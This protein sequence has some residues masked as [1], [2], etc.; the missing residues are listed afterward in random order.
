MTA[1]V[2][3]MKAYHD[4]MSAH[5]DPVHAPAVGAG[6]GDLDHAETLG[7]ESVVA[8]LYLRTFEGVHPPALK[9]VKV[10][11]IQVVDDTQRT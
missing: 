3:N 8:V 6:V 9:I 4:N 1:N 2:D 5:L 7:D 10:L 11:R